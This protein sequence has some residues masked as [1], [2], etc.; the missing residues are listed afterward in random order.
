MRLWAGDVL[1][2]GFQVSLA[3]F[4]PTHPAG[5]RSIINLFVASISFVYSCTVDGGT[6][7][8]YVPTGSVTLDFTLFNSTGA[9]GPYQTSVQPNNGVWV[10]GVDAT[11]LNVQDYWQGYAIV[12]D[13]ISTVCGGTEGGPRPSVY[14][15]GANGGGVYFYADIH[16]NYGGDLINVRWHYCHTQPCRPKGVDGYGGCDN[17]LWS[18]ILTATAAPMY[19]C[20]CT[21]PSTVACYDAGPDPSGADASNDAAETFG[22]ETDPPDLAGGSGSTTASSSTNSVI[23][24]ASLSALGGVLALSITVFICYRRRIAVQKNDDSAVAA[25][26]RSAIPS[27]LSMSV[28]TPMKSPAVPV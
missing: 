16:S 6:P 4:G 26:A 11:S 2:G 12:P 20:D 10:P 19:E 21:S 17:P 18:P 13:S 25:A 1:Y 22:P 5:Y 7:T 28:R 15:N 24:I 8:Q 23:L 9:M 14:I 27:S 3:A